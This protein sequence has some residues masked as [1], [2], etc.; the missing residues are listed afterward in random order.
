MEIVNSGRDWVVYKSALIENYQQDM[1]HELNLAYENFKNV[2]VN[3]DSSLTRRQELTFGDLP[4]ILNGSDP[5]FIEKEM[6]NPDANLSGYSFYN[7]FALTSPS[8]LYYELYC[9]LRSIIRLHVGNIP[10]WFQ[11]WLNFHRP[12]QVLDWHDH[13]W[14]YHGYISIDPKDTV[15]KFRCKDDKYEIVNKT[16]QIYFGPGYRE[17]KVFVNSEYTGP[18]LTLGFDISAQPKKPQPDAQFSLLPLL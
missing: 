2:F 7:V 8:P 17:H 16:G 9:Q 1:I 13:H 14:D 6:Q 4:A 10:L 15:T 5:N 3:V 11:C 12:D 18:R